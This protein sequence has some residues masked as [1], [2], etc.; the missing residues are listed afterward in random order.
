MPQLSEPHSPP[1]LWGKGG[2]GFGSFR[3]KR[4]GADDAKQQKMHSNLPWGAAHSPGVS[5]MLSLL[6][7][8]YCILAGLRA[9]H[10]GRAWGGGPLPWFKLPAG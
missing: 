3:L 4:K 5:L 6:G 9:Q 10:G 1:V 7:Q 2:I 8:P